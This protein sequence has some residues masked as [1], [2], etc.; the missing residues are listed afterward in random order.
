[1]LG[2]AGISS[3]GEINCALGQSI[4]PAAQ[5]STTTRHVIGGCHSLTHVEGSGLVGDPMEKTALNAIHWTSK[6]NDHTESTP[7]TDS[8][9]KAITDGSTSNGTTKFAAPHKHEAIHILHRFPF[10]SALKRMTT[11]IALDHDP[12]ASLRVTVKG[13][14]EVIRDMLKVVPA[15]YDHCHMQYSRQGE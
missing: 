13:A 2:I 5:S 14:S 3:K 12:K 1:M 8:P 4:L 15:G 10:T 11:V 9:I 6:R 7:P